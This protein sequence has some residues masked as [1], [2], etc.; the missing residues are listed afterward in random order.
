MLAQLTLIPALPKTLT[1]T[2]LLVLLPKSKTLPKDIPHGELLAA[3]MKRREMK[4][5]E[6]AKSFVAAN[7]ANGALV[8]WAMLD[9]DKDIFAL[10]TQIRKA[11]QAL[12][13][14]HPKV[15]S[16]AVIGDDEQRQRAA[17][18]AVYGAWV[19]GALLP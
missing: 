1:A 14:E 8:V 11:L 5:D 16:I 6:L 19:N 3:V 2:H 17:E 13:D 4:V 7:A 18:L 10:Q 12:L 9:F 15:V